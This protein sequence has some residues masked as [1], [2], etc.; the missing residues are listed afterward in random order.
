[1]SIND[2][3]WPNLT[4]IRRSI[5]SFPEAKTALNFSFE[6]I[7]SATRG[8][9]EGRELILAGSNNYLGLTYSDS[10]LSASAKAVHDY[11]TGTTGSRLANGTLRCHQLLEEELAAFFCR[12]N[13]TVFSTGY[14]ANIGVISAL[15]SVGDLIVA[16]EEC[17]ASI[18]DGIR[19]SGARVSRFLHNNPED[20]DRRLRQQAA[21]NKYVV[22]EGIYSMRGDKAPLV[23][24][25]NISSRN[26]AFLIVDEAHSFGVLGR[27]GRGLSE[28]CG[29]EDGV[30]VIV[31]TFSKSLGAVGGFA[32]TNM[33]DLEF[34]RLT[35]RSYI[36]SASLPAS[37][38][39]GARKNL[40]Q[41]SVG[42]EIREQLHHNIEFVIERFHQLGINV[43]EM[44]S[45][46]IAVPI[47]D[48]IQAFGVW[49][50]ILNQGVYVN[51]IAPVAAPDRKAM[52]RISISAA[53][54]HDDLA[55][56][57][58]SLAVALAQ[59]GQYMPEMLPI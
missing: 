58:Q 10:A 6:Q 47:G 33:E 26:G 25:A 5:E 8:I 44:G 51:L 19:L 35:S 28:E 20:L 9:A 29:V 7:L 4:Q 13:A 57:C 53:H 30:H 50:S 40:E 34:L 18:F 39:Q 43:R 41:L 31:G 21:S 32:V 23:E 42:K 45:P 37:I 2:G 11:G 16:D 14:Q 46:I 49:K 48:Y 52:L 55:L 27:G 36:F 17:H 22:V 24:I 38:I 56:I 54:T 1:M 15:A 59:N 3:A 12:R